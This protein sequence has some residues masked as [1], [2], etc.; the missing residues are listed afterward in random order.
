M[1]VLLCMNALM[2]VCVGIETIRSAGTVS[3][4]LRRYNIMCILVLKAFF[5]ALACNRY[6]LTICTNLAL[7]SGAVYAS[8]RHS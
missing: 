4:L 3:F 1:H 2:S 5:C 8:W 7:F 6:S